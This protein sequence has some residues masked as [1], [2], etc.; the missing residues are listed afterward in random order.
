MRLHTK[1]LCMLRSKDY[2]EMYRLNLRIADAVPCLI[3]PDL[4]I[5][6]G[7][8]QCLYR[9]LHIL[10]FS[11]ERLQGINLIACNNLCRL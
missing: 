6:Y 1:M 8:Q 3:L 4:G 10:E 11:L 5:E 2:A 7:Q 9:I